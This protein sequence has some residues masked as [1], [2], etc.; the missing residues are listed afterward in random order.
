[1]AKLELQIDLT[2][3]V[4]IFGDSLYKDFGSMIKEIVQNGHD[5]IIEQAINGATLDGKRIEV[6]FDEYSN[7][8]VV[9]DNGAGMSEIDIRENLNNFAKSKKRDI[10]NAISQHSVNNELLH[11]VGEYGVGFLAAMAISETLN[12]YSKSY[13]NHPVRWSYKYGDQ[14]ANVRELEDRSFRNVFE[15][16][17]LSVPETGTLVIS[18]LRESVRRK[19]WID[20]D[21]IKSSLARFVSLLPVPIF[22]NEDLLSGRYHAWA[23]PWAASHDDWKEVIESAYGDDPLLIIPVYSPDSELGVHGVLWIPE[24]TSYFSQPILDIY[25]KRMF[26][27]TDDDLVIPDWANFIKGAINS[28][29]LSRIVSG[30]TI[31]RDAILRET[32]EFIRNLIIEQF[33]KLRNKPEHEYWRILGPHDDAI[34]GSATDDD[35]FMECIWD[36]LRFP[37]RHKKV[38]IPDY[39]NLIERK[40]GDRVIYQFDE[41]SQYHSAELVQDSTGIPVLNLVQSRDGML[42]RSICG[43]NDIEI[44]SYKDLAEKQFTRSDDEKKYQPLI[45][46]CAYWNIFAEARSFQP[47]YFPAV[48]IEDSNMSEKRDGLLRGLREHGEEK[49]AEEFER[50]LSRQKS[51]NFGSSFYLNIDNEL[52]NELLISDI[53]QQRNICLA[54]Y[55]ISFMA[56]YPDLKDSERSKVFTSIT[57][58]L[59]PSKATVNA[60]V[61]KKDN[62]ERRDEDVPKTNAGEI[63]LFMI[64]PF[65]EEY[66][67]VEKAVRTVF[68]TSPYCFRVQ[69]ARD[70]SYQRNIIGNVR[71][72]INRADA[73]VAEMTNLNPNV[74]LELGAAVFAKKDSPIYSLREDNAQN[75]VPTDIKSELYI[76]YRGKDNNSEMIAEDIRASLED[77]GNPKDNLLKGLLQKREAHSLTNTLLSVLRYQFTDSERKEILS[78][79]RTV[80]ELIDDKSNISQK[81]GLKAEYCHAFLTDLSDILNMSSKHINRIR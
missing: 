24:R 70:Y 52:I 14:N 68:E 18:H 25:I 17:N 69:L 31:K 22:Y 32:S 16:N 51:A 72:H 79:Y 1:M 78:N 62:L 28:T 11:I 74:M 77:N 67:E 44:R 45:D 20:S 76:P 57:Q 40:T 80:E 65:S 54:L 4:E 59:K 21:D 60:E 6:A 66:E 63:I 33:R 53:D 71:A 56:A 49:F 48:L 34:K 47:R 13:G 55:N 9:S 50:I 15:E 35:E 3:M 7:L 43:S 46:A 61:G 8:L 37:T 41:N 75:D 5:A 39:L 2:G 36:K 64:T 10:E 19:Y 26:V 38:T 27:L 29:K 42:V 73:F 81:T 12:V 58:V 30:N 23:E